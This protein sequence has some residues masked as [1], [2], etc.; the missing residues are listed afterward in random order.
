MGSCFSSEGGG[1]ERIRPPAQRSQIPDPEHEQVEST[2]PSEPVIPV[3]TGSRSFVLALLLPEMRPSSCVSSVRRRSSSV[4]PYH[5][6]HRTRFL[7]FRGG[8][9]WNF[10]RSFCWGVLLGFLYELMRDRRAPRGYCGFSVFVFPSLDFGVF[11]LSTEQAL[12]HR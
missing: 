7:G 12:R 2:V 1:S 3:V 10:A 4:I 5:G 8:R 9:P 6:P 11:R